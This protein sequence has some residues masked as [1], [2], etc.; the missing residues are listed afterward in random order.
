[1][2][3]FTKLLKNTTFTLEDGKV[4]WVTDVEKIQELTNKYAIPEGDFYLRGQVMNALIDLAEWKNTQSLEIEALRE[5]TKKLK[6]TCRKR[7]K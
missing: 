2:E 1:M 6:K 4:R 5:L 3:D 7:K